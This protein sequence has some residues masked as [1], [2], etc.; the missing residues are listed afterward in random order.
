MQPGP[1][2]ELC[3]SSS[4]R[5]GA[6][7][8][9]PTRSAGSGGT[10]SDCFAAAKLSDVGVRFSSLADF[11]SEAEG[12]VSDTGDFSSAPTDPFFGCAA[13]SARAVFK[14]STAVARL[15][16]R[17]ASVISCSINIFRSACSPDKRAAIPC[18]VWSCG[19]GDVSYFDCEAYNDQYSLAKDQYSLAGVFDQNV[20]T[21]PPKIIA[22]NHASI[23]R[24]R[25]ACR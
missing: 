8:I 22:N 9:V 2:A 18:V 4:A 23:R 17:A 25:A 11:S 3:G 19:A 7:G 13:I 21:M 6:T 15:S 24:G 20:P 12:L 16:T 5:L 1:T 10:P 14:L